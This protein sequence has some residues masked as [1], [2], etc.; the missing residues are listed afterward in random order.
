MRLR[1]RIELQRGYHRN[2][3]FDYYHHVDATISL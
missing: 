2:D 3:V 1:I